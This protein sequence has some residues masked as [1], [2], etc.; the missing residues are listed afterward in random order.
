MSKKDIKKAVS[1]EK[2]AIIVTSLVQ[3]IHDCWYMIIGAVKAH[4]RLTAAAEMIS[5]VDNTFGSEIF[6]ANEMEA[7]KGYIEK[8]RQKCM[9]VEAEQEKLLRQYYE[10]GLNG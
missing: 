1:R 2:E 10:E 5:L 7:L 4:S 3:K 8:G 6:T 9:E